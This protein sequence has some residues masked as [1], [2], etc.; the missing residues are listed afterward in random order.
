M[1]FLKF[2]RD[3][4]RLIALLSGAGMLAA[5]AAEQKAEEKEIK[6]TPPT[7]NESRPQEAVGSVH[8]LEQYLKRAL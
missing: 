2:Y 6:A 8:I 5:P 7:R 1:K 3:N 4:R